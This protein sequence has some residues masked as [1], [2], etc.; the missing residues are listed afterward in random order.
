MTDTSPM[1]LNAT[2]ADEPFGPLQRCRVTLVLESAGAI[3]IELL[4]P[5]A[6]RIEA[7]LSDA[8]TGAVT[9]TEPSGARLTI[10][11]NKLITLRVQRHMSGAII[12]AKASSQ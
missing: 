8:G 1:A 11:R 5:E 10:A 4:W 7:M 9:V 3:Q 2:H 12:P 6:S